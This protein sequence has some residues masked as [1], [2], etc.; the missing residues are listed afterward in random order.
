M[1]LVAA[2]AAMLVLAGTAQAARI[3]GTD[4]NDR[5]VGTARADTISGGAGR[6]LLLGLGGT[7]FLDGGPGRDRADGGAGNDRVAVEYDGSRDTVR[8]GPGADVVNADLTDVVGADCELVG[9]RLSRDPYTGPEAQHES[10]AEPDSFTFG[11]TTVTTFQV[12]RRF[13]G[14][15]DNVGW[16]TSTDDGRSW[17]SGLLPG[18]T[19]VSGPAGTHERASDPVVAYDALHGVWLISTLALEGQVTRLPV[20]RSTDGLTWGS[21]VIAA[22]AAAP[23]S[24][25]F[26]K[27]WIA[28]DNGTSSPFRGRCYVVYTDTLRDD[29]IAL[30]FSDDGGLTWS[31]PIGVPVTNAVGA[32][33]VIQPNGGLVI[34]YLWLGRR[35]AASFSADGGLTFA[36]PAT[37]AD[38]QVRNVRGLRFFP[39]PSAT[40]DASGRVWATWHDCRFDAGCARNSVVVATTVDG[41]SWTA[42]A[43]VTSGRNVYIPAI[44]AHSSGRLAIAY[45][46]LQPGGGVDVELVEL[47]AGAGGRPEGVSQPRRLSAR[48]MRPEWMPDT[49]SGRMLADYISVHYVRDRPLV[50]WILASP[51]VAGELR[52]AAYATRG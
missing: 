22:E 23:N 16:A 17:R 52:Q 14:A 31:A 24:I 25:S 26:D 8:C 7:D 20:S 34:V 50:A 6:D 35:I 15:A 45:H 48:T 19:R 43:R 33:P 27:N 3:A 36:Q 18:L 28:C 12:G 39:L 32:F 30:V 44:G 10:E 9:R 46:V 37:V 29:R 47:R 5:L 42:P 38:L 11:R 21:P 1:R 41:R 51:P 49:T 2:L 13:G 4:A 40:A